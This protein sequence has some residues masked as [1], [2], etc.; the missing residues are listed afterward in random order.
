MNI[1]EKVAYLKGLA[2]GLDLGDG[3]EAKV[4]AGILDVLEDI[5]EEIYDVEAVIYCLRNSHKGIIIG[6]NGEMLKRI[7]TYARQDLEKM[8][9][10]KINL[11]IWVKVNNDWQDNN[12]IVKRFENK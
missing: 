10:T 6:K 9:Q 4:L 12:S 1:S 8:L 2:E 3:K 11:K 7:G 5:C